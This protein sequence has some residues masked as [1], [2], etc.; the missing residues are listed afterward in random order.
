MSSPIKDLN[1]RDTKKVILDAYKELA[2]AYRDLEKKAKKAQSAAPAAPKSTSK[3][4]VKASEAPAP[5]GSLGSQLSLIGSHIGSHTS[6]L[7][8]A[9]TA[10][11]VTLLGIREQVEGLTKQL[12][13]LYQVEAGEGALAKLVESYEQRA[14]AAKEELA[15]KTD[16]AKQAL[17]AKREAWA[18][19]KQAHEDQVA[20]EAAEQDK[21]RTREGEAYDYDLDQRRKQERDEREQ[22][23]KAFAAELAGTREAKQAEWDAREKAIADR[24]EE[25][26]KL[27]LDAEGLDEALADARKK[28]E[29]AG[30]SIARRDTKAAAELAKK[31]AEGK[32]RVFKLKIAGLEK[33]IEKQS[34]QIAALSKQLD[35]ALT[36]A[37]DLAV[38][39]IEG[40]SNA[41]SFEAIREIAMEQA[42][43]SGKGK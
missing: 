30:M 28:G 14:A 39:A 26:A 42:K 4:L 37:Q 3:A 38:K 41:T 8:Q 40:S 18:K 35:T 10:E 17:S 31:D 29:G 2:K 25:L 13:E 32:R 24:E 7:Q 1:N 6:T 9:L 19:E 12:Q 5:S 43:N 23:A 34:G 33:T 16:E 22:A 11:A 20:A 36:Q 15:T 21:A 27:E